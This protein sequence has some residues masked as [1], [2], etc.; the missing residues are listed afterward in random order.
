MAYM[1]LLFKSMAGVICPSSWLARHKISV[2]V[3]GC[4][5]QGWYGGFL[6]LISLLVW[7]SAGSVWLQPWA[8]EFFFSDSV[9]AVRV[10][11]SWAITGVDVTHWQLCLSWRLHFNRTRCLAFGYSFLAVSNRRGVWG[12]FITTSPMKHSF[13]SFNLFLRT[14]SVWCDIITG[15]CVLEV[16][17]WSGISALCALSEFVWSSGH[18]SGFKGHSECLSHSSYEYKVG[19]GIILASLEAYS[20]RRG[21]DSLSGWFLTFVKEPLRTSFG[22]FW[23]MVWAVKLCLLTM[24]SWG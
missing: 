11:L 10:G 17:S 6:L 16:L 15:L 4:H 22:V 7:S 1:P 9:Y 8:L 18:Y 21:E 24:F 2:I 19:G 5:C 3:I 14:K 23:A 12:V 20:R 13:Q